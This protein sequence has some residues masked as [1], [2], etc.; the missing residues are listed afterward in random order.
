VL[1]ALFCSVSRLLLDAIIDRRRSDASFRLELLVLRHQLHVLQ[2]QVKRPRWRS[3]DHL[4]LAGLSR[5]LPRP[6]RRVTGT[7][8][9]S[10]RTG[11]QLRQPGHVRATASRA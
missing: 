3:A 11:A 6:G 2:C 9:S 1:L 4:T 7:R 8:V 10:P 5:R